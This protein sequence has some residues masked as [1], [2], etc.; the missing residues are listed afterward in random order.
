MKKKM[1]NFISGSVFVGPALIFFLIVEIIPLL[2]GVY[3]SLLRWNGLSAKSTFIGLD[4]YVRIFSDENFIKSFVF[5]FKFTI[6]NVFLADLVAFALA[7]V[8]TSAIKT[9]N[10]LRT[11]FFLPNVLSGLI[12]GFIWQ[13]IFVRG[14]TTLGDVTH[15]GVFQLPWLGTEATGYWATIIVSVWQM[16]G[17]LMV[18]YIAG[19]SN[20]PVDIIEAADI[21]GASKFDV[22]KKI[23]IPLIMPSVTI[24]LFLA[25]AQSF[26]MFDLNFSLTHGA[27]DT[28]G[29]ALNIYDE[30]FTS[31]NFGLGS[32][33]AMVFFVIVS[34]I[35]VFQ[36]W[37]T[38][39][40]E[41]EA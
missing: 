16:A 40:R 39:S 5:T 6:V 26:K 2:M 35:S 34:V 21:D 31:N 25:I 11:I 17:Y 32:A 28:R 7:L 9:K 23:T 18:I 36:V 1:K 20:V 27:F 13:F 3:Y 33:K 10:V 29:V 38:K 41:V 14:F 4:N 12:L 15:L 24:C 30:A 37:I 19:L 8:L 22:L